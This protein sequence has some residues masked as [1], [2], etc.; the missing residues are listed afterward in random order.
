MQIVDFASH[1]VFRWYEAGDDSYIRQID[2]KFDSEMH[3]KHGQKCYP[4]ASTRP[5]P[6]A[7][8]TVTTARG[9]PPSA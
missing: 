6:P 5:Y 7:S 3:K 1:A 8:T 9:T 2:H 4:M